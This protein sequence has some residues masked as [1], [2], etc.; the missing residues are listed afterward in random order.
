MQNYIFNQ[1]YVK[2]LKFLFFACIAISAPESTAQQLPLCQGIQPLASSCSTSCILC[3]LNGF[4]NTTV[5]GAPG[6]APP[7]FCTFVVH[8]IGWVGFVAGSEDLGISVEVFQCTSGNSIEMGIYSAPNCSTS[9]LV[10]NCNTAMFQ[11]TTYFF[12]NTQ[13]LQPGCVYFLVFD[14]NG[15]ASCPFEVTVVSGSASAPSLSPPPVPQGPTALCPGATA[16]YTIPEQF[17][18]C[19][20]LWNAPAGSLINGMAPPVRIQ[21]EAG[22]SVDITF[23]STGGNVCVQTANPCS[24]PSATCLPV[25]VAPIPPTVLPPVSICNGEALEWIDGNSYG[26]SQTLSVTLTSWLGCDSIVRQ[27]LTVRPP[28]ITN[29]G[30]L[31]RCQGECVEIGGVSYCNQGFFQATLESYLGC[32]SNVVFSLL[33]IPVQAVIAPAD[34]LSCSDTLMVLNAAGSTNGATYAWYDNQQQLIG[35]DALQNVASGGQ[36][37]LVITK[38]SGSSTCRD[39]AA[40]LVPVNYQPPDL[41]AEGDTLDCSGAPAQLNGGSMTPGA[42]FFWTGPGID[43]LNQTLEDPPV[44]QTG[45]YILTVTNPSN[46]CSASDTTLI[47][48][49][50]DAPEIG[51]NGLD[52][53]TCMTV[54]LSLSASVQPP[55]ALVSWSGPSAFMQSGFNATVNTPGLYRVSAQSGNGCVTTLNFSVTQDTTSPLIT[56]FADTLRC[57]MPTGVINGGGISAD[58][59]YQWTGPAGFSVNDSV[60]AVQLPGTYV[61]IA[62]AI[63]GCTDADTVTVA[64]DFAPPVFQASVQ[65]IITCTDTVAILAADAPS[66]DVF[67]A[68]EGPSGFSATGAGLQVHVA[69]NYLVSATGWNGCTDTLSVVVPA[70]TVPPELSVQSGM[71][72]CVHP[73]VQLQAFSQAPGATFHW[74]G[75]NGF[76]ADIPNPIVAVDGFYAI[77]VTGDNGCTNT[78]QAVVTADFT[79]P[80]LSLDVSN[81]LNCANDSAVLHANTFP[82]GAL[83]QWAGPNGFIDSGE[84][85]IITAPGLYVVTATASNGCTTVAQLPVSGDYV[86]PDIQAIGDTLDCSGNGVPLSGASLTIGALYSWTGPGGFVSSNPM[87]VVLIP[88]N[89]QLIVTALNGCTSSATAVV[90]PNLDAPD[91]SAV[92]VNAITCSTPTA[93]LTAQS[94]EPGTFF[95]WVG[96]GGFFGSGATVQVA[97]GGIYT[98]TATAQNGCTSGAVVQVEADLSVP[99]VTATGNTLDCAHPTTMLSGSSGTPG[100]QL[101]WSGPGGFQSGLLQPTVSQAGIYLLTATGPNGCTAGDTAVVSSDLIPPVV[102]ISI[103]DTLNC[104]VQQ[105]GVTA[106]ATPPSQ[107]QWFGPA[108]L[109]NAGSTATITAPGGYLVVA[110]APNGCRDSSEVIVLQDIL[111]PSATALGDTLDCRS[112]QGLLSGNS[113]TPGVSYAWVGPGGFSSAVQ[114]PVVALAGIY[115]LTVTGPNGCRSTAVAEVVTDQLAPF[116]STNN[117]FISC[118]LPQALIQANTAAV[119]ANFRWEGPGGFLSNLRNIAVTM[120]G[121]YLLTLTGANGCTATSVAFITADTA[122]PV[123]RLNAG[124][125]TCG[126]TFATIR[127]IVTPSGSAISWSGPQGIP[128][129]VAEIEVFTPG[130][131]RLTA[132]APNGCTAEETAVVEATLP[133]WTIDLG[134]DTTV[135]EDTWVTIYLQTDISPFELADIRWEPTFGCYDCPRQV[136]RAE[137]T[138]FLMVRVEDINGCVQEDGVTVLTRPRGSIYVPNVFSPDDDGVNDILRIYPGPGIQQVRLFSIYDRWGTQIFLSENYIPDEQTGVWDGRFRGERLQPAVFVWIAEVVGADGVVQRYSGDVLL[139]R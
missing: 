110:I 134:P 48:A 72:D 35:T 29:L 99:D 22:A 123:I 127:A 12:N 116:V 81:T 105:I 73:S 111:A 14:N 8:T 59:Q 13:P 104:N 94:A 120:P 38:V 106:A 43:S 57:N 84:Q 122:S 109:M 41:S 133:G 101:S 36:Y 21:G 46:G 119:G 19:E 2:R 28:V 136:F 50:A 60:A 91:L 77:T 15:P 68:W 126:D 25:T 115:Q 10:S 54:A 42:H 17:G 86:S 16:T 27:Q 6:V 96:P 7:D 80:V 79:T 9:E 5:M 139:K 69:G 26:T 128:A 51:L 132:T 39:T 78:N 88:G 87:P 112:P 97:Q 113:S 1:A 100:V 85:V 58:L 40:V 117:S 89:Y 74:V 23:G 44:F 83:I 18:A 52:T 11:N 34:T 98:V 20:Y 76:S 61:L 49:D 121:Q 45:D 118:S 130:A 108:G 70:D 75:P 66:G 103:P 82:T 137:D 37:T 71:L 107:I 125:L 32:D 124:S 64:G 30:T 114:A 4:T 3:E 67:F 131:Y 62:T 135:F 90:W 33:T 65:G 56:A 138:T 95:N 55:D 24:Q 47:A 102:A 92:A 129:P 63:N 93:T 53:L 31:V